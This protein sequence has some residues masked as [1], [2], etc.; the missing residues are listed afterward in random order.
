MQGGTIPLDVGAARE[1]SETLAVCRTLLAAIASGQPP[2]LKRCA[3][4]AAHA[5]S[6]QRRLPG[7]VSTPAAAAAGPRAAPAAAGPETRG[8]IDRIFKRKKDGEAN[9][10]FGFLR[11]GQAKR[12]ATPPPVDCPASTMPVGA[13]PPNMGSSLPHLKTAAAETWMREQGVDVDRVRRVS[14][15]EDDLIRQVRIARVE[16]RWVA[17]TEC[18]CRRAK[19]PG[20]ECQAFCANI[21]C[22]GSCLEM[23]TAESEGT[24]SDESGSTPP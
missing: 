17:G 20:H 10:K 2:D 8:L 19:V 3:A 24:D 4:A 9:P 15:S 21:G 13:M 14:L 5:A 18:G 11:K 22:N 12:G 16:S 23:G 1:I 7:G 6:A